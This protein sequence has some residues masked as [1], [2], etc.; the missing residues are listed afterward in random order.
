MVL[1][2]VFQNLWRIKYKAVSILV[3]VTI[4]SLCTLHGAIYEKRSM[5]Y[6]DDKWREALSWIDANVEEDAVI[7]AWWDY[8]YWIE[9]LAKRA[10]YVDNGYR[11]DGKIR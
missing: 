3:I 8:G 10:S 5:P 6:P 4:L 7:I 11:P 2:F 1:G 9:A